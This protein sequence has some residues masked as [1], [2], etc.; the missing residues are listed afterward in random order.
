MGY[1]S[2]GLEYLFRRFGYHVAHLK[3]CGCSF[4]LSGFETRD[5]DDYS[6]WISEARSDEIADR[7][8]HRCAEE[9]RASLLR[10][11]LDYLC[12]AFFKAHVE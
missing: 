8:G 1:E 9:T 2:Y 3:T 12:E 6:D 5:F 7:V 10:Q 11:S 4:F